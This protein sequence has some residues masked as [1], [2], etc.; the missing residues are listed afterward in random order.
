MF[1]MPYSSEYYWSRFPWVTVSLIIVCS[2]VHSVDSYLFWNS[3]GANLK[4]VMSLGLVPNYIFDIEL[5]PDVSAVFGDILNDYRPSFWPIYQIFTHNF[6]HGD[7]LHFFFNMLV[8][9]IVGPAVE[10][11]LG[12][13]RYLTLYLLGGV[14]SGLLESVI[15]GDRMIVL[16]GASGSIAAVTGSFLLFSPWAKIKVFV[17]I[18]WFVIDVYRIRAFF[19][20]VPWF[21][22][23]VFKGTLG[24]EDNIAHWAHA[25]GFVVGALGYLLMRG[26]F[27][28]DDEDAP[29]DP[30]QP[31]AAVTGKDSRPAPK[32]RRK[33][34]SKPVRDLSQ[35]WT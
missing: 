35:P 29:D 25:A 28:E 3:A 15:S 7:W 2:I 13:A 33:K 18:L 16:V 14:I 26:R 8:L 31:T 12:R 23:E 5:R 6:M 30:V 21:V 32:R 22:F 17:M 9:W 27:W 34:G 4:F 11:A 20:L 19:L 24:S 1:F 10:D